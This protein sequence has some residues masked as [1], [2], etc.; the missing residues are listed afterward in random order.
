MSDAELS[1]SER[2]AFRA[3]IY[4]QI[5]RRVHADHVASEEWRLDSCEL[6]RTEYYLDNPP[7]CIHLKDADDGS[8]R[9]EC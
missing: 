2:R 1:T 4:M 6:C 8:V 3:S 5:V 9:G 7:L